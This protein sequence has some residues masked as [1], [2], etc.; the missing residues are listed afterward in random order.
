MVAT[1]LRIA[2]VN[3]A[4]VGVV[5]IS[6]LSGKTL[7]VRTLVSTRA[8][9]VVG[10]GSTIGS[11]DTTRSGVALIV[12]A[13]IVIITLNRSSAPALAGKADLVGSTCILIVARVVVV[14]MH[15]SRTSNANV[16]CA[17]VVV[18]AVGRLATDA[19]AALALVILG[20]IVTIVA[21]H[22]VGHEL[23]T[24]VGTT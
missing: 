7:T 12:G 24:A 1:A 19:Y 3:G 17:L 5:T 11:E 6:G 4:R 20:A 22:R 13:H 10:A 16:V 14:E 23:A 2:L 15:A 8:R 9:I 21:S 18:V